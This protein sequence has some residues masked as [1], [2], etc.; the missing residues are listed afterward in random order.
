MAL[1]VETGQGATDADSYISVA[2]ADAYLARCGT[3]ATWSAAT[4]AQKEAALRKATRFI[5]LTYQDAWQ[6]RRCDD[7]QALDW[8]RAH[9]EYPRGWYVDTNT[10][11]ARIGYA[12]AEAA[13]VEIAEADSL[14]PTLESGARVTSESF[15]AGGGAISE[16]KTYSGGKLEG[17][18][19]IQVVAALVGP[20]T[21][22]SGPMRRA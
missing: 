2:D 9:V 18:K 10:V 1:V 3:P 4:E 17:V 20:L 16:S 15:S 21:R 7:D 12:V 5:D 13:A 6:G 11:P 14:L 19:E 22:A 8:P